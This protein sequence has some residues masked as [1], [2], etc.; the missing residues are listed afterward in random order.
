MTRHPP[1]FGGVVRRDR[2]F[3]PRLDVAV[4]PHERH[5]IAGKQNAIPVRFRAHRLMAGGPHS[6][7]GKIL[8]VAP[9]S[10]IVPRTVIPP[11]IHGHR[12]YWVS[13]LP[14]LLMI[15]VYGTLPR[16][17]ILG[18]GVFAVSSSRTAGFSCLAGHV[19]EI[20]LRCE[21]LNHESPR[22]SLLQNSSAERTIGS[23]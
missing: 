6:S 11:A 14:A 2:N 20:V 23:A 16:M 9:L 4:A 8:H 5:A 7:V 13:P 21:I 3:H 12:P 22:N 15:V 10:A 17:A 18:C 19:R 1:H